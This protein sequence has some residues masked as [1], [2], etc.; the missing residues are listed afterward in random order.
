MSRYKERQ[1]TMDVLFIRHASAEPEGDAGDEARALTE[2]GFAE[3]GRT[4]RAIEEMGLDI[5]HLLTSPL[6]RARQTAEVVAEA[7]GA[8]TPV[9][10]EA[11]RPNGSPEALAAQLLTLLDEGLQ[12]VAAVGHSPGIDECLAFLVSGSLD[13]GT[14]LSK[15]GVGCVRVADKRRGLK[16]RLRWLMHREQLATLATLAQ[17]V[18]PRT[19]RSE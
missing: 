13:V 9:E 6:K 15:A 12:V 4:A 16:T 7:H 17:T 8:G 3:A 1:T 10:N 11:L 5:Q 14:S 19:P 18:D 2:E